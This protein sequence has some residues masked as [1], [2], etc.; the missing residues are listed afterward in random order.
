MLERLVAPAGKDVLDIGCGGGGLV[1]ELASRGSRVVG[2][3]ISAEQLAPALA[4]A[5]AQT[6]VRVQTAAPAQ[7]A[8]IIG[9]AQALPIDDAS[10]DVA[11]FMRTLHH[12]PP[13][14]SR[15]P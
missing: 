7:T 15:P 8:Y 3:E 11:V 12:V 10:I 6:A 4:R 1:R 2:L 13:Q 14:T 9:R 5:G